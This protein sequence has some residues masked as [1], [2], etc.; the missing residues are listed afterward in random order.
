[1]KNSTAF[2]ARP[3][4]LKLAANSRLPVAGATALVCD[5]LDAQNIRCDAVI[6]REGE[7]VQDELAEM[8][9]RGRADIGM[10]KQKI[11]CASNFGFEALAQPRD[12][13]LVVRG[14]LN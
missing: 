3:H 1:M 9:I 6:Q 14:F 7:A 8:G 11:R 4:Q 5:D 13:K 10:L 2:P 12:L